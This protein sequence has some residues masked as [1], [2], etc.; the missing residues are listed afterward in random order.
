MAAYRVGMTRLACRRPAIWLK[1]R[2]RAL[3]AN[4]CCPACPAASEFGCTYDSAR[5]SSR[6]VGLRGS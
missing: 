3:A 6:I 5:Q 2:N 4:L 1:P